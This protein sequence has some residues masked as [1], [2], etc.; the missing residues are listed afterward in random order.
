MTLEFQ[1]FEL[2][3]D[4][5]QR[6]NVYTAQPDSATPKRSPLLASWT[7]G[8]PSHRNP[9]RGMERL[10]KV[11]STKGPA[12]LFTGDVWFDVLARG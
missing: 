8:A 11:T 7:A 2:A 5:G 9:E 4:P 12:E 1:A 10:T 6:L 3:G